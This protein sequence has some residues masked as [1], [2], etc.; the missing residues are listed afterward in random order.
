MRST[1]VA[2]RRSPDGEFFGRDIGDRGRS[3]IQVSVASIAFLNGVNSMRS[4]APFVLIAAVAVAACVFADSTPKKK[5]RSEPSAASPRFAIHG[6][7]E[8]R[9]MFDCQTG[10]TWIMKTVL[11]AIAEADPSPIVVWFRV[12]LANDSLTMAVINNRSAQLT[13]Y[14]D[15]E[16]TNLSKFL[17]E[18]E[19]ELGKDHPD[20]VKQREEMENSLENSSKLFSAVQST[21]AQ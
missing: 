10:E 17:A 16:A 4:F 1:E 6:D 3:P 19:T 12:P 5:G 9:L 18:K 15:G 21:F 20:L 13:A 7:G 2:D 14:N 11:P 8:N